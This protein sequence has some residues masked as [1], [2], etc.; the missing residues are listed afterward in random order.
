MTEQATG[1]GTP[2]SHPLL[3]PTRAP[4]PPALA[5]HARR[6]GASHTRASTCAR[7]RLRSRPRLHVLL[8]L[9]LGVHLLA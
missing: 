5:T 2:P 1:E 3:H 8:S 7:Q 6:A 4:V 9:L